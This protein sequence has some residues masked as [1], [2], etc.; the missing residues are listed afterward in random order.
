MAMDTYAT[1]ENLVIDTEREAMGQTMKDREGF[2]L[3]RAYGSTLV[4]DKGK[5]YIDFTAGWNVANIGWSRPEVSAAIVEQLKLFPYAPMWCSTDLTVRFAKKLR[6]LLPESLNTFFKT[7]GGTE[8]NEVAIKM[9]RAYTGKKKIFSFYTE[10]HGQT[11][12][13]ISLGSP[14]SVTAFEPT[15]P[16]FVKV[17]P[18]YY[19][20]SHLAKGQ[21]EEAFT[22][23]CL[24]HIRETIAMEGDAAAFLCEPVLTCPGVIVPHHSF[25]EGLRNICDEFGMLLIIDEVGTGFGRTGKMFGFEHYNIVPDMITMAKAISGGFGP[26]GGVATS[27]TIAAAMLGKGGTSTYGWHA[28]SVAAALQVLE[29]LEHEKLVEAAQTK[30]E[31][32]M[33]RLREELADCPIVGE[34]RGLGLEIGI[35]LVK[36]KTTKEPHKEAALAVISQGLQRGLHEVWSGRTTTIIIMPPLSI[37]QKELETG[38]EILIG[39]IKE[40]AVK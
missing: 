16:G 3:A 7:T 23:L 31:Y 29:I 4:D 1:E 36:D 13:S 20:R 39:I 28:V 38:L 37:A 25:F 24:D 9:A 40:L 19:Y 5:E 11:M 21:T 26:L 33:R 17:F 22:Q 18:P 34:I 35:E 27:K 8:A 10:Y 14:A 12:G 6:S 15:V 32:V 2:T 30:G